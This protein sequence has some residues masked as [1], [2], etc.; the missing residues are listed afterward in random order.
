MDVLT[1]IVIVGLGIFVLCG[2]LYWRDMIK[3]ERRQK[4]KD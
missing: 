1:G 4:H 3:D 2:E